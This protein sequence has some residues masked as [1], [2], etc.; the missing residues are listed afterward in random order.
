MTS[1]QA[2]IKKKDLKRTGLAKWPAWQQSRPVSHWRIMKRSIKSSPKAATKCHWGHPNQTWN[3]TF[4]PYPLFPWNMTIL[5]RPQSLFSLSW[6]KKKVDSSSL[7][8][9][10]F[11]S[12][13]II[14]R[15]SLFQ[16]EGE[17]GVKLRCSVSTCLLCRGGVCVLMRCVWKTE[18]VWG[19]W[20]YV[21]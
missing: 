9:T 13:L 10:S 5:E 2:N 21:W 7:S 18:F 11:L 19:V 8:F 14:H 17:R 15:A 20:V 12:S 16:Q 4:W 1:G 6:A 3:V